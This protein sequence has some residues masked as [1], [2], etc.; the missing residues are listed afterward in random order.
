MKLSPFRHEPLLVPTFPTDDHLVIAPLATGVADCDRQQKNPSCRRQRMHVEGTI[1]GPL[2]KEVNGVSSVKWTKT[3]VHNVLLRHKRWQR[4][5]TVLFR[6]I[7]KHASRLLMPCCLHGTSFSDVGTISDGS[8]SSGLTQYTCTPLSLDLVSSSWQIRQPLNDSEMFLIS[9]C[10][11]RVA[12]TIHQHR[13]HASVARS[14][15]FCICMSAWSS[16]TV[17]NIP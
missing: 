5:M 3:G 2:M 13:V 7:C 11:R 9:L 8:T 16:L 6:L 10:Q 12:R 1:L 4:H 15:C 17:N 14:L